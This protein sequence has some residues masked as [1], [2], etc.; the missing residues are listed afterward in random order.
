L[1]SKLITVPFLEPGSAALASVV[2]EAAK[3][4]RAVFMNGH[5]LVC[6]GED[7]WQALDLA[8]G[9]EALAR[10]RLDQGKRIP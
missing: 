2:G 1:L 7:I 10:I 3:V 4:Y 5:G 6:W 8:E 9:L